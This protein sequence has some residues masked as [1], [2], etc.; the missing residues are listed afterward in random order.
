MLRVS[1]VVV[2]GVEAIRNLRDPGRQPFLVDPAMTSHAK[3]TEVFAN[4]ISDSLANHSAALGRPC[5]IT[6]TCAN[7]L[8][9]SSGAPSV[10]EAE[11]LDNDTRNATTGV[12][13]GDAIGK[14]GRGE[15]SV[16]EPG[17]EWEGI[18]LVSI[19][20]CTV[21]SFDLEPSTELN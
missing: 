10:L 17:L 19:V 16:T 4:C 18:P 5:V 1:H 14:K 20:T 9:S 12:D 21:A 13:G 2:C 7:V 6:V 8:K 3:R 15:T 11:K